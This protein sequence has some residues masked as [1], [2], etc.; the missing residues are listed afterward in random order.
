MLKMVR[1]ILKILDKLFVKFLLLHRSVRN[2]YLLYENRDQLSVYGVNRIVPEAGRKNAPAYTTDVLGKFSYSSPVINI[3]AGSFHEVD[4]LFINERY[5]RFDISKYDGTINI[6]GDAHEMPIKSESIGLA[7]V[8]QVL[9]HVEKPQAII[10]SV[11][12]I[13]KWGGLIIIS[14]PTEWRIHNYP[15]DYWRFTP[16]GARY[17][18]KSFKV[19]D[20]TVTDNPWKPIKVLA[21]GCK[22]RKR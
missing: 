13:L 7:L 14:V 20:L 1:P 4:N 21:T 8:L 22:V 5:I 6:I 15:H 11:W 10:D 9:E 16:E 12:R 3:G 2:Q 17:L 18:L 19:L